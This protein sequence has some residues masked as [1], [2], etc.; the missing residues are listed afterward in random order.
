[1]FLFRRSN[2]TL[3]II[4]CLIFLIIL[5]TLRNYFIQNDNQQL[6]LT[7]NNQVNIYED[8]TKNSDIIESITNSKRHDFIPKTDLIQISNRPMSLYVHLDLKGAAP[9]ISYFEKLFPLLNKWGVT[10]LCIE[11]EDMFPF[12]GIVQSIKHKQAYTKNDIEKINQLAK[13]NQLDV[14]PL[15]QTYGKRNFS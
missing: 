5:F 12:D 3:L 9:K 2:K 13:D 15:L 6:I 8:K 4:I 14:M 10:G 1:M 11:Y 7:N